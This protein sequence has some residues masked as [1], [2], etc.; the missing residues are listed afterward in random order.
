MC[1][2]VRGTLEQHT[3]S[4]APES[5]C[6]LCGEQEISERSLPKAAFAREAARSYVCGSRPESA[7]QQPS[8]ALGLY[9]DP[10][11]RALRL[12]LPLGKMEQ[13]E[14]FLNGRP[15]SQE[16]EALGLCP[17]ILLQDVGVQHGHRALWGWL[18]PPVPHPLLAGWGRALAKLARGAQLHEILMV[19]RPP[20]P[21]T[22]HGCC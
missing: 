19:A 5:C 22:S 2:L 18:P 7:S 13:Y 16:G 11:S 12:S 4:S 6:S 9:C 10:G 17:G 8:S 1:T 3:A 14:F 21:Q 20:G 15:G